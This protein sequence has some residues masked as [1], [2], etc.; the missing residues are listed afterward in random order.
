MSES[1]VSEPIESS[2]NPVEL[3]PV[4]EGAAQAGLDPEVQSL[5]DA[6]AAARARIDELARAYQAAERD[7]EAFKTRVQ[8]EREQMM[9]VER[10]KVAQTLIEAIDELEL[11]L[12]GGDTSAL[13]QG[14]RFIRDNI[15]RK[16]EAT[17]VERVALKGTFFD[18]RLA[19]ATD[20]EVTPVEADDG[21]VLAEVKAC[22]RFN[23]RVV[24]PGLVRVARYVKPAEA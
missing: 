12:S 22:Y 8:R 2:V 13:A 6:L 1:A 14:V 16:L 11:C 20:A 23:G 9:E 3:E 4:P 7:R 24:R 17:G 15:V 21:R 5:T 19:E 10:G 18:P